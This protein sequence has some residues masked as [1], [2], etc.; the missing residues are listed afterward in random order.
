MIFLD[1]TIS[2]ITQLLV[3]GE[4]SVLCAAHACGLSCEFGYVIHITGWNMTLLGNLYV[5]EGLVH[6]MWLCKWSDQMWWA[7]VG[8]QATP[9]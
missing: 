8:L 4:S 2:I 9:G 5:T 6:I 7:V 3:S 1:C